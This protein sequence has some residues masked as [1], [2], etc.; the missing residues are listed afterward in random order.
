[1]N[2]SIKGLKSTEDVMIEHHQHHTS[3]SEAFAHAAISSTLNGPS[4]SDGVLELEGNFY[5][6]FFRDVG[7]NQSYPPYLS[8][9]F[10]PQGFMD[11]GDGLNSVTDSQDGGDF[12]NIDPFNTE[13][14]RFH[15]AQTSSPARPRR[16]DGYQ[17]FS[18][19]LGAEAFQRSSLAGWEPTEQDHGYSEEGNLSLPDHVDGNAET[20]CLCDRRIVKT[21]LSLS[22]RD[23]ILSLVLEVCR[24]ESKI[25]VVSSFPSF[26]FFDNL[27]QLFFDRHTLQIDNWLHLPTFCPN[28]SRPELITAIAGAGAIRT[29]SSV[30]QNLGYALQESLRN[31]IPLRLEENNQRAR[32][33]DFNQAYFLQLDV[34]IWSGGKRKVELAEGLFQPGVTMLRRARRFRRSI[35]SLIMPLPEDEGAALDKKWRAWAQQE[36]RKR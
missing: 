36:A 19:A 26:E 12:P 11:Y 27:I 34:R 21:P 1:M 13:N 31:A 23:N 10:T 22:S 25:R 15:F 28:D 30:V 5:P 14:Y 33:I 35:G 29:N 9:S 2:L 8:S 18:L 4:S 7:L 6:G 32:S 16:E 24:P 17:T 3:T 20:R